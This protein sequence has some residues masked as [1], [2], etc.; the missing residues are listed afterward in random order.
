MAFVPRIRNGDINA[1]TEA[2]ETYEREGPSNDTPTDVRTGVVC[3][4]RV[5]TAKAQQDNGFDLFAASAGG[6]PFDVA[7]T[8][9]AR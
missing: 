8:C 2:S 7:A 6:G 9:R 1:K 4:R 5:G 3:S